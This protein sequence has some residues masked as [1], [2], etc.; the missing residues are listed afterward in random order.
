MNAVQD[1]AFTRRLAELGRSLDRPKAILCISAHWLTEGSWVT[2]MTKPKTIHDFY[3]FPKALF[4]VQYPAP[5]SPELARLIQT[6]IGNQRLDPEVD[7]WGLDH[8]TWS[9]LK[10]M[11]PLA[12]TPVLQLLIHRVSSEL[13]DKSRIIRQ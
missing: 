13:A 1:N 7:A 6:E 9:V 11:Y 4:D 12:D 8:G 5:G 2:H 3:G 10:H